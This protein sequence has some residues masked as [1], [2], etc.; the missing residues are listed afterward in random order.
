MSCGDEHDVPITTQGEAFFRLHG[1]SKKIFLLLSRL[2]FGGY[3][4]FTNVKRQVHSR[5]YFH[6][7]YLDFNSLLNKRTRA[8][9]ED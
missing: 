3:F 5:P 1:L 7:F 9:Y 6:V 8:K 2:Q 4:T